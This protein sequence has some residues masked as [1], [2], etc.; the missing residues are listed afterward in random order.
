MPRVKEFSAEY[1]TSVEIRGVWHKFHCAITVELFP[2]DGK[3]ILEKVKARTWDVVYEEI[4]K[5]IKEFK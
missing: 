4:E 3:E 2:E 1:G 5:Q